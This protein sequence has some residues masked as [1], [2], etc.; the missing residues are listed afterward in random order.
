[1]LQTDNQPQE[2]QETC[3]HHWV[4]PSH[5]SLQDGWQET[6]A[7]CG[8]TKQVKTR[9][10]LKT[11]PSIWRKTH[12]QPKNDRDTTYGPGRVT[13]PTRRNPAMNNPQEDPQSNIPSTGDPTVTE[14]GPDGPADAN[15]DTNR[16]EPPSEGQQIL[17]KLIDRGWSK[18]DIARDPAINRSVSLIDNWV[19]GRMP[20][21]DKNLSNLKQLLQS[22][23]GPPRNNHPSTNTTG[24]TTG[25][26]DLSGN[27]G[28]PPTPEGQQDHSDHQEDPNPWNDPALELMLLEQ[29]AI[30]WKADLLSTAIQARTEYLTITAQDLSLQVHPEVQEPHDP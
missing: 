12:H 14:T 8:S 5:I 20:V 27:P 9:D 11:T 30:T 17:R 7:K 6:C 23:N 29:A 18:K 19:A 28:G 15:E 16:P 3:V 10:N 26:E 25:A 21:T 13:K 22:G 4:L 1:M 2:A 24:Q